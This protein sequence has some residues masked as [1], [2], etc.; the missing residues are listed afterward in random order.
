[1]KI[2]LLT[3]LLSASLS[4]TTALAATYSYVADGVTEGEYATS[5]RF[6]D[7]AKGQYWTSLGTPPPYNAYQNAGNSFSFLGDLENR[8]SEDVKNA[9]YSSAGS[10]YASGWSSNL[11][12]DSGTCWYQTS[13]NI[14]QYWQSYYGVFAENSA[15]LPYGHTYDRS[16]M[17][18]LWGIQSLEVGMVFYDNLTSGGAW[19]SMAT[20]WY[21]AGNSLSAPEPDWQISG[22]R[23]Q[24][25]YNG[26]ISSG[27][28]FANYFSNSGSETPDGYGDTYVEHI[29]LTAN[30]SQTVSYLMDAM[31]QEVR[32]GQLET[33]TAGQ[34]GYLG[35]SSDFSYGHAVTCYGFEANSDG[36]TSLL[37]TNSDDYKY[38]AERVY[39]KEGSMD[40]YSDAAC[41][42]R[43]SF[44]NVSD[45]YLDEISYI[46]TPLALK[47][48]Y[49]EYTS[50]AL[51]W[52][53]SSDTWKNNFTTEELPT[54]AAGW[55]VAVKGTDYSSYYDEGRKV[56]FGDAGVANNN[57]KVEGEVKA[58][59]MLL[60]AT[61]EDGYQFTGSGENAVI[62]LE[63]EL[64]KT[65]TST[66][67]LSNL[68]LLADAVSL[69]AGELVV[70]ADA[71]LEANSI[72]IADG[73][74]LRVL[75]ESRIQELGVQSGTAL[76]LAAGSE[77]RGD[78]TMAAGS[79]LLFDL[80]DSTRVASMSGLLTLEGAV[81]LVVENAVS[82]A[83]L[84]RSYTNEIALLTFTQ[85]QSF[86]VAL[87]QSDAGQ[88]VY[89]N[90]TL[91][92]QIPE[93][94]GA[95]LGLSALLGLALRRRRK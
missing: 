39:L 9:Q 19:F 57:I 83:S 7:T 14:I 17:S 43:W 88:I 31:G 81:N 87:L 20:D 34:L 77:L 27:G 76:T 48:M 73:A 4:H 3:L 50:K 94:S 36:I 71:V 52:N 30:N 72:T 64:S 68:K 25:P 13:S 78:V 63:G 38:G 65:G 62:R 53:G 10:L 60:I 58:E 91:Y 15:A 59:S 8:V 11:Q 33:T 40:L 18:N 93:P 2:K 22:K 89:R 55:N 86:D 47:D 90:Q 66:D 74:S 70:G 45:W 69:D 29:L 84:R 49:A 67:T 82:A 44:A 26:T 51:K 35:L 32:D 37:I 80:S 75:G 24:T 16:N 54:A 5:T 61:A 85:E 23:D 21:L 6:Y 41:T 28:Y 92:L 1:M 79:Y 12:D 42:Q 56:E 46:N 95:V